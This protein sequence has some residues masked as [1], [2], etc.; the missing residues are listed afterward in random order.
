MMTFGDC[1][2][3]LVTFFVM[4]IAFTNLEEAKLTEML[5][6]MKGALGVTPTFNARKPIVPEVAPPAGGRI[7]GTSGEKHALTVDELSAVL[8]A[9]EIFVN[10]S[11]SMKA[12]GEQQY[13]IVKLLEEGLAVIIHAAPVFKAG[14]AE[15]LEGNNDLFQEVSDFIRTF[16]NEVRITCVVPASTVVANGKSRT[17]WGL[18][19]ERAVVVKNKLNAGGLIASERFSIGSDVREAVN[20]NGNGAETAQ[21]R[22]EILVVGRR[23]FQDMS[24][25]KVIINDRWR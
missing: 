24:P 23:Q 22:I 6:A 8:P 2:S 4:L 5:G 11:S 19:I 14:A 15:L 7:K 17:P 9:A 16:E 12:G 21:E 13:V 20:G 10:R 3:L 25:G 18:G 1:M